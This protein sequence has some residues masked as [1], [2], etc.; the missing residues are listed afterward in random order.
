MKNI[1]YIKLLF[2]A[3]G[4]SMA[5]S[6]CYEDYVTDWYKSGIYVAYQYDL[7]TFVLDEQPRFDFTVG[8]AGVIENRQDRAVRVELDNSLLTSDLSEFA[9][10]PCKA[11]TAFEGLTGKAPIGLL[12]QDYVST[13]V[14]AAGISALTPLPEEY[15]TVTGLSGMT[16]RKG[17]H[18]AAATI[19]AIDAI[20]DDAK[21][22]K[23]YYALGFRVI[24]AEADTLV[25]DKSFEIIAVKCENRFYGNWNH[26]GKTT[27]LDDST[28]EVLSE[29]IYKFAI[30]QDDSKVYTLTTVSANTV[31]TNRMANGTGNLVLKFAQDGTIDVSDGTGLYNLVPAEE[32]S[33]FNGAK[34]LQDRK[35]FL[36]YAYSNGDG[37]TTYVTDTLYFRN[38]IRDG[39]NEWQDENPENYND[40]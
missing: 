25:R 18:T 39:V 8:L 2:C 22:F 12:C 17:S 33:R 13:E 20:K 7:R 19:T 16:I 6:G 34:R 23:P 28:G 27:V 4:A 1:K 40:L 21:A 5:V 9:T 11:F 31:Q 26:G 38:R 35:L 30:P 32:G 3:L 10:E 24:S 15:F 36:N 37:S 29:E 14:S